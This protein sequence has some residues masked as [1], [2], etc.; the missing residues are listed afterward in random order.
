M[1]FGG[2]SGFTDAQLGTIVAPP[3]NVS[4]LSIYA[5]GGSLDEKQPGSAPRETILKLDQLANPGLTRNWTAVELEGMDHKLMSQ[6]AWLELGWLE[7]VKEQRIG[8]RNDSET[9]T[10]G[11]D[12]RPSPSGGD[13]TSGARRGK[14]IGWW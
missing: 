11:N 7:F 13:S 10:A 1:A 5:A 4:T 8:G 9:V 12:N 6:E 3:Q 14:S 2:S